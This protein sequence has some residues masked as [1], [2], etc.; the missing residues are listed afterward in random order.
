MN[1]RRERPRSTARL[2]GLCAA[3]AILAAGAIAVAAKP[4]A[5]PKPKAAPHAVATAPAARKLG[6]TVLQLA[7]GELAHIALGDTP[8]TPW[9]EPEVKRAEGTQLNVML[10]VA[11]KTNKILLGTGGQDVYLRSYNDQLTGPTLRVKQGD[12]LSV[13]LRNDLPKEPSMEMAMSGECATP[14]HGFNVTNLHT[15]GLHISP[16][17]PSDNVLRKVPPKEHFPYKF[18]ILPAGNPDSKPARQYPGTFWYHAHVHG[19]TAMQLASGMAGAL[20]VEDG[21][22]DVVREVAAADERLFVFQQFAYEIKN[23]VGVIE[24]FAKLPRNWTNVVK[25]RTAINGRMKPLIKIRPG[26][27]ERWRWID[28]GVF[29]D[30]PISIAASPTGGGAPFQMYRIAADGITLPK[31]QLTTRVEMG[32]G[33]RVDLL[34]KAPLATG[35][36]YLFKN[37]STDFPLPGTG[38]ANGPQIDDEQI[39]AQIE[40]S[41]RDCSFSPTCSNLIPAALRPP[42]DM[43]PTIQKAEV[44]KPL[45][46]V[47]FGE[48]EEQF[49]TINDKCFDQ[50]VVLPEF[51]KRI[52]DVEEWEITNETGGAHPFHIHVNA[53]Q[54]LDAQRNPGEWRDTILVPAKVGETPGVV[55]FRTRIEKFDGEFVL[56]CHILL[57]E[58]EGMMQ[59]VRVRPKAE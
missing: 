38:E 32:P 48:N 23:G 31:P 8:P 19:S 43:L 40:V 51:D 58:D 20:I 54:L 13:M 59:L 45:V 50:N 21:P 5:P 41:G 9:F 57:H 25:K 33:N 49:F 17:D 46:K 18:D 35:T 27:T 37:K 14:E 28:S 1:P 29:T 44:N 47:K 52:G 10:K 39:L 15:H 56:H 53:F 3:G 26:Q 11:Y 42:V 16:K 6:A 2:R 55:R 22:N 30:L 34:V 4:P 24:D 36:Y 7:K 12:T